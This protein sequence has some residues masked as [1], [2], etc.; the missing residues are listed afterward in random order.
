VRQHDVVRAD[1]L[2][3]EYIIIV[4]VFIDTHEFCVANRGLKPNFGF[5]DPSERIG[6]IIEAFTPISV[7]RLLSFG[8]RAEVVAEI[9]WRARGRSSS[10]Q[11]TPPLPTHW[12]S[13]ARTTNHS[14][15]RGEETEQ[16][17]S[18]GRTRH[19]LQEHSE[20]SHAHLRAQR[21][22]CAKRR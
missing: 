22:F 7:A 10:I 11:F 2:L 18:P 8:S 3:F 14:T 4:Q 20:D 16:N 12:R 5:S 9:M 6:L 19:R 15:R 1:P 17:L 21:A 13:R